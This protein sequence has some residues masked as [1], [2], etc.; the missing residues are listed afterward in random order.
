MRTTVT[1]EPDVERLL[2]QAM[3]QTG[4]SFKAA[5]NRALRRGLAGA[6]PSTGE[7]FVVEAQSLGLRSGIDPTKMNQLNDD[8]EVEAY[9][10]VTRRLDAQRLDAEQ[11]E[12]SN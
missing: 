10:E 8:L 4:E 1:I 9:L 12:G 6:V 3:Q 5:L 2:R 11:P 7:P